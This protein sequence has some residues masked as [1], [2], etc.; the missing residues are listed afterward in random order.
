VGSIRGKGSVTTAPV[1]VSERDLRTLLGIVSHHRGDLPAA[2]LP[3]SLL[4]E[5]QNQVRCDALDFV[6]HDTARQAVWFDQSV[7]PDSGNGRGR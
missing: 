3:L 4:A 5:L 6:G 1:T 7:P 2:G